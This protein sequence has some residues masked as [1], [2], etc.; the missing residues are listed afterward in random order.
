M[1]LNHIGLNIAG[2]S[3]VDHFYTSILKCWPDKNFELTEAFSMEVFQ[4]KGATRVF[5]VRNADMVLELFLTKEIHP[6]AYQHLCIEV[7]DRDHIAEKA[8]AYGY[9]VI[10]IKGKSA[11]LLFIKDKAGNIFELQN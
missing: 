11:D 10:R 2:A 7:G 6:L 9:P 1:K 5:T 4:Q 8:R 3:E